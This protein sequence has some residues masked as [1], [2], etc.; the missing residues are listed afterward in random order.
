MLH[1]G[2]QPA[3]AGP[4]LTFVVVGTDG[5]LEVRTATAGEMRQTAGA[6][7][8]LIDRV[9]IDGTK[10]LDAYVPEFASRAEHP[11]NRAAS[12]MLELL[13]AGP[14]LV[15]GTVVFFQTGT[16]SHR[17][18]SM[19]EDHQDLVVIAHRVAQSALA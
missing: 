12:R 2:K 8:G 10:S 16:S 18:R 9:P 11:P 13:G 19:D 3:A 15:H 17:P 6:P 4:L 5:A 1:T 14:G 7:Y